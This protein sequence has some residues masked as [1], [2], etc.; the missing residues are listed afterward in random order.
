MTE[1]S[2]EYVEEDDQVLIFENGASIEYGQFRD[3]VND[4]RS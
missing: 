3:L 2:I 1:N 4:F